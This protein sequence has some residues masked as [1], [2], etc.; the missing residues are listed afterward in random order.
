MIEGSIK[1]ILND[2]YHSWLAQMK[3]DTFEQ[4]MFAEIGCV[5]EKGDANETRWIEGHGRTVY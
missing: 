3:V 2:E 5:L 4:L 1:I